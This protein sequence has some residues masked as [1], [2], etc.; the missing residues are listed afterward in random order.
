MSFLVIIFQRFFKR[1]KNFK[2]TKNTKGFYK[3]SLKIHQT[4]FSLLP[5]FFTLNPPKKIISKIFQRK[6]SSNFNFFTLKTSEN[7]T[8]RLFSFKAPLHKNVASDRT[9]N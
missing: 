6:T 2:I 7:K 4:P 5:K 9:E 1:S 8:F 3:N